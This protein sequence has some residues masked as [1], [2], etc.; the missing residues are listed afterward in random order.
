MLM[1]WSGLMIYW[2]HDVYRIG[3][4]DTTLLQFF[5]TSFYQALH[6]PYKLAE[7]MSLLFMFMWLF[8]LN[9]LLDVLYTFFSG[10]WRYLIPNR[11]SFREAWQVILSD[12]RLIKF[13]R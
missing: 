4:R 12:L 10:E 9:G 5:P 6:L 2:A 8:M 11:H 7:G 1:I 3:W 13:R